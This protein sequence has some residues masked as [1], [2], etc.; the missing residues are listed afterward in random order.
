[1]GFPQFCGRVARLMRDNGIR[2]KRRRRWRKT[3]DS[4]HKQP[5]APNILNRQSWSKRLAHS[6]GRHSVGIKRCLL[7][8]LKQD[9]DGRER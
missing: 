7:G 5:A 2:A 9:Y 3:A 1:M 8:A 4:R 6:A